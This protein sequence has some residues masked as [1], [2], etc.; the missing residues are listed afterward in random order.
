MCYW[1]IKSTLGLYFSSHI[2]VDSTHYKAHL[3]IKGNEYILELLNK[4][5]VQL[6][7]EI[8]K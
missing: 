3:Y 8:L 5:V 7:N 1:V 4:F 2:G 6:G